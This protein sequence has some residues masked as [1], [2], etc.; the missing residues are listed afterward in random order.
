MFVKDQEMTRYKLAPHITLGKL[1]DSLIGLKAQ[2][3]T[4]IEGDGII[5]FIQ[6]ISN[7]LTK[8]MGFRLKN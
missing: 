2:T 6:E 3:V 8:I 1:E 5:E 7:Y 4:K